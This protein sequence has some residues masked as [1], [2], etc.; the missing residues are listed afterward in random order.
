MHCPPGY[1]DVWGDEVRIRSRR[2]TATPPSSTPMRPGSVTTR[3]AGGTTGSLGRGHFLTESPAVE[4]E[5]DDMGK[6]RSRV[7]THTR[8]SGKQSS[9]QPKKGLITRSLK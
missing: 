5:D 7:K 6:K 8:K 4:R 9:P 1:L 3:T 2:T